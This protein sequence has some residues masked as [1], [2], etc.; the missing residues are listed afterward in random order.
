MIVTII[1][2]ADKLIC[3]NLIQLKKHIVIKTAILLKTTVWFW[4]EALIGMAALE[5]MWSYLLVTCINWNGN[6][7]LRVLHACMTLMSD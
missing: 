2:D 6:F 1:S 4:T 5:N 3:N 7:L